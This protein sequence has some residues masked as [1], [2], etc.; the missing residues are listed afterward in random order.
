MCSHY[1]I[2]HFTIFTEDATSCF[3]V[4]MAL[5][6]Q[7]CWTSCHLVFMVSELLGSHTTK[8]KVWFHV[9]IRWRR[10]GEEIFSGWT[11]TTLDLS[12][13]RTSS[14]TGTNQ[15]GSQRPFWISQ[16]DN[17][18]PTNEQNNKLIVT[19]LDVKNQILK[20]H[21]SNISNLAPIF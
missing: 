11:F 14:R 4:N 6:W 18:Q 20:T 12:F 3:M 17:H 1:E 10:H 13:R 21:N 16:R 2:N 5:P 19:L 9:V 15:N 7:Q 8:Q